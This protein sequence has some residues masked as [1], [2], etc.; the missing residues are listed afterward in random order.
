MTKQ[1]K[2]KYHHQGVPSPLLLIHT[3]H[4]QGGGG[5][6]L[7]Y[8]C[9]EGDLIDGG[10]NTGCHEQVHPLFVLNSILFTI[11]LHIMTYMV[12]VPFFVVAPKIVV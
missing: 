6:T 4:C 12:D 9:L 1:A 2:S 8:I 5:V 7:F 3:A 11:S 10:V